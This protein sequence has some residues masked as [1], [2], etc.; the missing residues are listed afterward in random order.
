MEVTDLKF[1]YHELVDQQNQFLPNENSKLSI[2]S[3]SSITF[4]QDLL[5]MS[6]QC[7]AAD[8]NIWSFSRLQTSVKSR[9]VK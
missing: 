3:K 1:F 9:E 5:V 2:D 7:A 4:I 8:T 6:N